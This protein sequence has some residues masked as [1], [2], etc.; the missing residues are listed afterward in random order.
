LKF[1]IKGHSHFGWARVKTSSIFP[2]TV[3][4]TGYAYETIPNKPITTGET[5]SPD[6]VG[7]SH[8]DS[9]AAPIPQAGTLG[10]LALGS[11]AIS[12]W[13]REVSAQ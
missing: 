6:D 12:I 3:Y 1:S 5:R 7:Q 10:V 13:R 8:S 2:Y 9:L 11:P 4:L